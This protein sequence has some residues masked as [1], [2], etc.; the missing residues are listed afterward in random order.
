[1]RL[2]VRIFIRFGRVIL[3]VRSH[4]SQRSR[5]PREAQRSH[6]TSGYSTRVPGYFNLNRSRDLINGWES[7][8]RGSWHNYSYTSILRLGLAAGDTPDAPHK[9]LG[10]RG[11]STAASTLPTSVKAR[12]TKNHSQSSE[13]SIEAWPPARELPERLRS[14]GPSIGLMERKSEDNT[15][16]LVYVTRSP[17]I[18]EYLAHPRFPPRCPPLHRLSPS[19]NTTSIGEASPDTLPAL[20]DECFVVVDIQTYSPVPDT[21]RVRTL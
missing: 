17:K 4:L 18:T 2:E 14:G 11:P 8:A 16:F 10:T 21:R 19:I 1:M 20:C 5:S 3:I 13:F 15:T 6:R 9:H 12:A 7:L